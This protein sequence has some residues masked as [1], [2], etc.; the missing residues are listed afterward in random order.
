[1]SLQWKG[2]TLSWTVSRDDFETICGPLLQRIR[3]PLVRALRDSGLT[4][5]EID[6]VV[7]AGGATRM[8]MVRNVVSRMFGRIARA[9]RNPDHVIAEGAAVMAGLLANDE[10]L[11]EVVMTDVCPYTL[12][13]AVLIRTG[14]NQFE[15]NVFSPIIDRNTIVP[16]SRA[17]RFQTASDNQ[18]EVIFP[19]YQGESRNVKHN[20]LLGQ[21]SVPVPARPRGEVSVDCRFTYDSDGLLDVDVEVVGT[22]VA[23]QT[24]IL[25]QDSGLSREEIELRREKL[26]ALKVHPRDQA[27][28]VHALA[29]AE[30]LYEECLAETREIIGISISHFTA[31]L[32]RQEPDPI[33]TARTRLVELLNNM[34]GMGN[35]PDEPAT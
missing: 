33:R 15:D 29:R 22:G 6:E 16:A 24:T 4:T 20:T 5:D 11:R 18:T 1:M 2:E 31:A 21:I 35:I 12:G 25:S 34:E 8:P 7:L 19:I 32:E 13:T 26:Q 9:S 10:T 17:H 30:R 28:N 14:P 23:R 3:Q 27:E